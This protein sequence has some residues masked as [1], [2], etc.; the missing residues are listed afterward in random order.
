MIRDIIAKDNGTGPDIHNL[1]ASEAWGIPIEEVTKELRNK[2][3]TVVFGIMYGRQAESIAEEIGITVT[4]AQKIIDQ[5]L[6]RY[7]VAKAWL[8]A[9][10]RETK[11]YRQIRSV[12][13]RLRRLPGIVS[14]IDYIREES[15]RLAMNSPIQ[16][17]ASDLNCMAAAHIVQRI[18]REGRDGYLL[19][20][21]HDS[22]LFEVKIEQL[23]DFIKIIVEE[24]EKSFPGV[25]VPMKVELSTGDR[26]GEMI[27]CE[28]KKVAA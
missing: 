21:V 6:N 5:F 28:L 25:T 23:Q 22:T 1:T 12:F 11:K 4:E 15:E 20:L 2:A 24:M 19:N 27:K 13:G 9:A 8:D 3:K 17:A 26:W 16:S 18:E 10:I 14:T 7:S